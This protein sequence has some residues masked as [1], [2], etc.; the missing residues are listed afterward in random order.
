MIICGL[1]FAVGLSGGVGP[2]MKEAVRQRPADT[3]VEEREEE[4]AL[5]TLG[6]E[7]IGIAAAVASLATSIKRSTR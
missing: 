4:G 6:G 3:L 5:Q 7:V 1:E 2:V